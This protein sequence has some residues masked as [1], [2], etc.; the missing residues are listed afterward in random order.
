MSTPSML[1]EQCK[2]LKLGTVPRVYTDIAFNNSEQYLTELFTA[3]LRAREQNR[4][5][6]VLKRAAFPQTKTLND[7]DWRDIT[8]PPKT[9]I[10]D[11]TSLSFI[12]KKECLICMGTVGSGKTHLVTAL[13]ILACLAGKEVRFFRTADL[14]NRLLEHNAKGTLGRFT[15]EL[16]KCD[17]LILDE[18]GFVPLHRHGAEL[19]FNVVASCYEKRSVAVT[20]NLKFGEWNTVL[21]DNR[22][23]AALI[24]RLVHHAHVL[25]F[26]GSSWRLRHAL[27]NLRD[28]DLSTEQCSKEGETE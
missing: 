4:I 23:T 6:Q 24:D 26:S 20:T 18:L 17:L 25:A 15:R 21:N 5:R 16:E 28:T 10:D 7:F 27:S 14:A 1:K 19:L 22:L 2:A 8:L 9:S 3:E 13:G 12:S 11:L